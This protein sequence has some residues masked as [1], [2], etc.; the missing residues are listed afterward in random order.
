MINWS[1]YIGQLVS[2]IHFRFL[3]IEPREPTVL[4]EMVMCMM[5]LRIEMVLLKIMMTRMMMMMMT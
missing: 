4:E 5:L 1:A 3:F 2:N